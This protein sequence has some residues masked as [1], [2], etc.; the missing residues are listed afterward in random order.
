MFP[1]QIEKED[2]IVEGAVYQDAEPPE[3]D[4]DL[5][6]IEMAKRLSTMDS[7]DSSQV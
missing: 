1:R 5:E 7:E 6:A 3:E 2:E 4:V